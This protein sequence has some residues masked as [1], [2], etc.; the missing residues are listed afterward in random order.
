MAKFPEQLQQFDKNFNEIFSKAFQ[1]AKEE[2]KGVLGHGD[3]Q[4]KNLI[5]TGESK[6]VP[7]DWLDFG[8]AN[9]FYDLGNLLCGVNLKHILEIAKDPK[10]LQGKLE[11]FGDYTSGVAI[12]YVI[13]IGSNCRQILEQGEKKEYFQNIDK[14]MEIYHQFI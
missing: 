9:M 2:T 13:R 11:V 6:F 14:T 12:A 8:L 5:L 10:I 3:F 4:Q 7:I 1:A